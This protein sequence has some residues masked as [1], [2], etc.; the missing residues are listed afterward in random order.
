MSL[1]TELEAVLERT[2]QA[3][4]DHHV[5][6]R[7]QEAE[8]GYREVLA[9]RPEHVTATHRLGVLALQA[10]RTPEALELLG[11]AVALD[12]AAWRSHCS[13]GQAWAILD[14]PGPALDSFR[15]AAALNPDCVE[16][17][18]GAGGACR[19]L[20]L[21]PE[22]VDAFTRAATLRPQSAEAQNNLGIVLQD[23]GRVAEAIGAFGRALAA[24]DG[25]RIAHGNLGNA[26]MLAGRPAQAR[27]VLEAA[28]ARWPDYVDGWY[29]LGNAEFAGCRFEP[30]AAAYQQT[31]ALAPGHVPARNNLGNAL[32]A[33][34][35]T[36]QAL[37]AYLAAL[38]L[39][40]ACVDACNNAGAA[41]RDLG[42]MD[43]AAD[44]LRRAIA[45][46][47]E[48]A[49][50]HCNLGSLL[51]DIGLMDQ[52]V[53]SFRRALEL[54]PG[55]TVSRSN[56]A[57]AVTF[58]PGLGPEAI[59]AE[60]RAWDLAHGQVPRCPQRPAGAPGPGSRLRIGYV[61]PDFREHCQS[62]FTLPLLAHHDHERFEI[63]C[64][65]KVPRPDDITRRIAG[66]AD[67]WRDTATLDD[68]AVAGLV[69]ADGIDI[70]VDLT[71]HMA[72]GRPLL[73][74][75]KPAPVQVAWLAYPGTT[76]LAAMD[77][78]LTDPF[79]D[80]PGQHDDW[81]SETSIRLADTFWCY[82]PLT[83]VPVPGPLPALAGGQVTFG[84]LNNFCK[85][86]RAVLDL[87]AQVLVAVPGSRLLLLAQPG[88]HRQGVLEALA[89][90][91][92]T[93]DRVEFAPFQPRLQY[94][95]L[96]Q[97]VDLGLDTFPYN[98]HTTSLDAFWMGVPVVTRVGDTV[99]GRAGWSQLRNLGL[100]SLAADSDQAFV[101]IAVE[102]AR[103]LPGLARLRAG[104]RA[105][106]EASP[107][108]DGARFAR[109][110]EE[111]FQMMWQQWRAKSTN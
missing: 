70:L 67:V 40:P 50:S 37:A 62:L 29:N 35:R 76:G 32:Q 3:A 16:A 90:G 33:L 87:W 96:H 111:A 12:P 80:P 69:Q 91:G 74:A 4:T 27:A 60:N 83:A 41:A 54:A 30:A 9:R 24:D 21:G 106:M 81:Y 58:L 100:E 72:N 14:R 48:F 93:P 95:A 25:Y 75:R 73:F 31:L 17:W 15:A 20:G 63:F 36:E 104:L 52:A 94:L 66:H 13:L 102:L 107:L 51:K 77:Y 110:V 1:P 8:A 55:D 57:Y 22:A 88:R 49:P 89:A 65:A 39:D 53:A 68:Q 2:L 99:V 42:R 43:E 11:R 10:G 86:N 47:P 45:L 56:L 98:G 6:G 79:L 64:Y 92:V 7:L 34:G 44:L 105:R 23:A 84:S 5:A 59:L 61:S 82:D 28:V 38:D 103:D 18:L 109:T 78:R 26:L 85:V 46:R 97:R 19:T 101:R 108:M 71:M